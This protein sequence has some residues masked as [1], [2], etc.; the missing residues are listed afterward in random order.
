MKSDETLIW[1]S[2]LFDDQTTTYTPEDLLAMI[3]DHAREL[4][5]DY[6]EQSIDAAVISVPAYFSQAERKAVLY[7]AELVN[8]KVL[9]LVNANTAAGLNYGVFRRKD[10]NSTGTTFMF[11]DMGAAGTTA[12]VA[13]Y[14]V[15]KHKEDYEANPQLIVRGVGFVNT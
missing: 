14:N 1:L 5:T 9:Q 3:M 10:F 11:F 8:L 7:A 15:V 6:G 4:A 13:T 2:P 12:T